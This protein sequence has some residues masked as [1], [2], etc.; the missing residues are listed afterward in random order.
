MPDERNPPDD[1]AVEEKTN[2]KISP[3][4]K[5]PNPR[6]PYWDDGRYGRYD[7]YGYPTDGPG[8]NNT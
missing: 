3:P 2:P 7:H 6:A 8:A 4:D 1:E 5:T